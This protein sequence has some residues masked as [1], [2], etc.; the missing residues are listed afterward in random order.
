MKTVLTVLQGL[1]FRVEGA[2]RT[3]L[4]VLTVLENSSIL[5]P[6]QYLRIAHSILLP[7]RQQGPGRGQQCWGRGVRFI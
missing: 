5:L 7:P 4:L 2:D 6:P 1:G 3:Y